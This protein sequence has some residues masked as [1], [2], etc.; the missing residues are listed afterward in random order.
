MSAMLEMIAEHFEDNV[1]VAL[2][3][4]TVK[5]P[6]ASQEATW[7]T[8]TIT[9]GYNSESVTYILADDAHRE[10]KRLVE[11][12][13]SFLLLKYSNLLVDN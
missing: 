9:V 11:M 1:H 4:F 7:Y 6:I 3:A 10:Y 5:Q 8:V 13:K 2:C 12:P